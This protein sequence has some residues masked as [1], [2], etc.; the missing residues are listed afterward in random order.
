M[1]R[2]KEKRKRSAQQIND[3]LK[4]ARHRE[5]DSI[6]NLL[7]RGNTSKGYSEL[8][9]YTEKYPTDPYGH[10]LL[11]KFLLKNSD[12]SGARREFEIVINAHDKNRHSGLYGI[13]RAYHLE[14][15]LDN[16]R[17]YYEETIKDNP[18]NHLLPYLALSSLETDSNNYYRALNILYQ[19]LDLDDARSKRNGAGC[20]SD[21]KL[22]IVKNLIY[23]G[24]NDE[25][26]D[27]LATIIPESKEQE[28][29]IAFRH[30][31]IYR[32]KKQYQEALTCLEK[33]RATNQKDTT[34]Y[35]ATLEISRLYQQM[36]LFDEQYACLE[37]LAEAN[38]DFNGDVAILL[39]TAKLTKKDLKGA[40]E[41]FKKGMETTD[42]AA[43]NLSAFYYSSLQYL[44]GNS[45]GAETTLRTTLENN[46]TP[47]PLNYMTLI[48]LLYDQGRYA[49]AR[50]YIDDIRSK[51]QNIDDDYSFR[52]LEILINKAEEKA[53]P[54]RGKFGYIESQ[55]VEYSIEDAIRH[56]ENKHNSGLPEKSNFPTGTDIRQIIEDVQVFLIEDNKLM[57]NVLDE[58]QIPYPNAGYINGGETIANH[59][60]I[61][62]IP[63][64]KQIVTMHPC[65]ESLFPTRG[66][67]K[68]EKSKEKSKQNDR[69]S[70]F[71]AR[72]E[73]TTTRKN[74]I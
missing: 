60:R 30:G 9:N 41:T 44:E 71:N 58:Y 45:F 35:Q 37:E 18:Y 5:L 36:G 26:N 66:A 43:R 25:A 68:Q 62:T 13:A 64:T 21:I 72:F 65:E 32:D 47:Y 56:I 48:R 1:G 15:D 40:K 59:I 50:S 51:D 29:E 53:L 55:F 63:G 54:S 67:I 17:I 27:I 12:F 52:R 28:R 4:G 7:E 19:A 39:G 33:A 38:M 24:K 46:R 57:N 2:E 20:K 10:H 23:L 70:K 3:D 61:K 6:K 8:I 69:I 14:G 11:G 34:Y 22:S 31:A 42:F 16:A 74:N 49:E 73:K